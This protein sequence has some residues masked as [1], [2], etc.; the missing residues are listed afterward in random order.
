[1]PGG[2]SDHF[3]ESTVSTMILSGCSMIHERALP[4][5]MS[6]DVQ[7]VDLAFLLPTTA[8]Q[9]DQLTALMART[10]PSKCA[11]FPSGFSSCVP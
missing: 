5:T 8:S 6:I 10:S 1:M 11:R 9:F 4:R 2:R 3:F 7:P